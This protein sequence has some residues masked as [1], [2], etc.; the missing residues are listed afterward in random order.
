MI[1][2]AVGILIML[3]ATVLLTADAPILFLLIL[4]ISMSYQTQSAR[5]QLRGEALPDRDRERIAA[6]VRVQ[7]FFIPL[8][9]CTTGITIAIILL[10]P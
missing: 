5:K 10:I 4:L 7:L 2:W 9:L 6:F 8:I 3:A 1:E